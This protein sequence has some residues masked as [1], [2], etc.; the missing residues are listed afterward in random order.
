MVSLTSIRIIIVI[1]STM[2][3]LLILTGLTRA[4]TIELI[5]AGAT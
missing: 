5:Q 3:Y 1:A 2:L 4:K